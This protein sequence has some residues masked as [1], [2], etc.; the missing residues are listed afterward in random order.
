MFENWR[1]AKYGTENPVEILGADK[2]VVLRVYDWNDK[3]ERFVKYTKEQT[4]ALRRQRHLA[5]L[6]KA[7]IIIAT[8][9]RGIGISVKEMKA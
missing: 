6:K 1:V 2:S 4:L 3:Q 8:V 7:G 5:N 9:S